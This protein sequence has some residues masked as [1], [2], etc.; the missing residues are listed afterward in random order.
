MAETPLRPASFKG[1]G[2][3]VAETDMEVGRRTVLHEYPYRDVPFGEDMGRAARGFTVSAIFIGPS[4][5]DDSDRLIDVLEAK[6]AGTLVHPWRG[7]Q[8]VQLERPARVRYPRALGGRIVVEMD[9]REA[10]ENSEPAARADTDAQLEAA[11]DSAQAAADSELA[12]SWLD[13]IAGYADEA[14]AAVEAACATFESYFE[15]YDAAMAKVD[16]IIHS[17]QTII[18]APLLVVSRIQS[19]IQTLV[20]K[21]DTPFSGVTAWRKLLK[22]EVLNPWRTGG[23][24][25]TILST[26]STSSA[27]PDWTL[28][29]PSR[30]AGDLPSMPPALAAYVRRT[31]VIEA[32]RTLPTATFTTKADVQN[33]RAQILQ[34][35]NTEMQSASDTLYPAL[36]ALRVT[37]ATSIQARLPATA[38]VATVTTQTSLPA[39][40]VAYQVTGAIEV[41]DD[42]VARNGVMHPG[43]VPAGDIEVLKNA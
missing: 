8:F 39:L 13:E 26:S 24:Y 11:A 10:G 18:N 36:Q 30:R 23:S 41:A 19:R 29:N 9:L 38:D 43:F 2:F 31:L 14:A 3:R 21:L 16:R 33:A 22:D 27:R 4:A 1:V 34:A 35:L 17:V 42:L 20:G 32:A 6:G 25:S 7:T 15:A 40:V 37:V 5:R 12:S 28:P